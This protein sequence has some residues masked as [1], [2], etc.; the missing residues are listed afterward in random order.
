MRLWHIDI[1]PYLPRTQLLAQWRELNLI[2]KNQPR[3]ILINYVYNYPKQYLLD[4]AFVVLNEMQW[5]GYK[6]KSYD[7][8]AKYFEGINLN[9]FSNKGELY[10]K[11]HND[12]YLKI[13]YYNLLEKFTRGQKDFTFENYLRLTN[14]L[15]E[16][17]TI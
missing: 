8:Y 4:Y 16:R 12:V 7:N 3:H 11:E 1:I 14:V 6:I 9:E 10:F 15:K 13:C 17:G 2:F 5:R